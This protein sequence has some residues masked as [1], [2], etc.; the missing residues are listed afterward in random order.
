M[1]LPRLLKGHYL[2]RVWRIW[3]DTVRV[4]FDLCLY[5]WCLGLSWGLVDFAR[6][7]QVVLWIACFK[8]DVDWDISEAARKGALDQKS[9]FARLGKKS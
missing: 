1:N 9:V 6:S 5:R 8:L 4:A 2:Y 3:N 7:Y